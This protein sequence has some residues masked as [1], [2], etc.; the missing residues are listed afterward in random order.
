MIHLNPPPGFVP[1]FYGVGCF[2]EEQNDILLLKRRADLDI[3]PGKLGVPGGRVNRLESA[4]S[5]MVRELEEET[6]IFLF[7]PKRLI[8][9]R[10][11]YVQYPRHNFT[12]YM[13]RLQFDERPGISINT[14]EHTDFLWCSPSAALEM[15]LMLDEDHC[16]RMVYRP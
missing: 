11:I 15:D 12:Y 1:D 2:V 5:A 3:E 13:F 6:G 9:I 14:N 8:F 16:I 4:R 10:I 7:D